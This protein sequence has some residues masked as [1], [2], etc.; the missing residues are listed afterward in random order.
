MTCF[1]FTCTDFT[2]GRS[3]RLVHAESLDDMAKIG[4]TA[5]DEDTAAVLRELAD[6]AR[7]RPN[8]ALREKSLRRISRSVADA[9]DSEAVEVSDGDIDTALK[10]GELP[11]GHRSS[12]SR[13]GARRSVTFNFDEE[14]SEDDDSG[15]GRR[16]ARS[17]LAQL[18]SA[19][20]GASGGDFRAS[21]STAVRFESAGAL[22][23][24]APVVLRVMVQGHR[25][26][27]VWH[28]PAATLE[29]AEQEQRRGGAPG[30]AIMD[31]MGAMQAP[32][33]GDPMAI[34][35]GQQYPRNWLGIT[36]STIFNTPGEAGGGKRPKGLP[37]RDPSID[38]AANGS[39]QGAAGSS[40]VTIDRILNP[41]PGQEMSSMTNIV[42]TLGD[43][44]VRVKEAFDAQ[45]NGGDTIAPKEL[46][47]TMW[48]L[49][50][51]E[52]DMV[53][54]VAW[55]CGNV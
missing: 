41:E 48:S 4:A 16:H 1:A 44:I 20:G 12:R 14:R 7:S 29:D 40:R 47:Q 19:S 32:D 24:G 15:G 28:A 33:E 55:L 2:A 51:M 10:P 6:V 49:G 22:Q 46:T 18:A 13:S 42:M 27:E 5:G 8:R 26:I 23:R 30:V 31:P 21:V 36:S 25:A 45:A 37:E 34:P 38:A 50:M 53:R 9:E 3:R 35:A 54:V 11:P 43:D 17:K 39:G 52:A